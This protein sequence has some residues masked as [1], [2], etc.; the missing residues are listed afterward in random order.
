MLTQSTATATQVH[1][2]TDI[3]IPMPTELLPRF[4][5]ASI[6]HTH[7]ISADLFAFLSKYS[8]LIITLQ[9]MHCTTHV[10]TYCAHHSLYPPTD[11]HSH[12]ILD[13]SL[14]FTSPVVTLY[15]CARS[16]S[17]YILLYSRYISPYLHARSTFYALLLFGL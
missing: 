3:D 17:S 14:L 5:I 1:A 16:R 15:P 12:F 8:I 10:P 6:N 7:R 4:P 11:T 9:S 2:H 13:S